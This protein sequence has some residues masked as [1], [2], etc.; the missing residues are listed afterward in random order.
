MNVECAPCQVLRTDSPSAVKRE[1]GA[2]PNRPFRCCPRNGKQVRAYHKATG[3]KPG[4]AI[5]QDLQAR[6]PA[7]DKSRKCHGGVAPVVATSPS[8]THFLVNAVP[9]CGDACRER[10]IN[11][12]TFEAV[13]AGTATRPCFLCQCCRT[14]SSTGSCSDYS[15]APGNTRFRTT[16]RRHRRRTQRTGCRWSLHSGGNSGAATGHRIFGQ[17]KLWGKFLPVYSRNKWWQRPAADRRNAGR[18][19]HGR[20]C[21]VEPPSC[22][23]D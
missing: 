20:Q 21:F 4:K 1:S 2:S 23:P 6:I 12:N 22:Q 8:P 17:R 16:F 18:L 9:A 13:G 3:C 14:D 11:A 5:R 7:W 10:N 19:R 15:H